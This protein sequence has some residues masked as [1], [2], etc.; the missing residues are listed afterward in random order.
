[1]D[2][3]HHVLSLFGIRND[4]EEPPDCPWC[5]ALRESSLPPTAQPSQTPARRHDPYV[6]GA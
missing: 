3:R 5:A 2:R 1:M 6:S 4:A